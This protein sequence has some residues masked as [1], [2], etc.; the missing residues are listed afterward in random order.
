M[1]RRA[2]ATVPTARAGSTFVSK[3]GGLR[4]TTARA[5]QRGWT[6]RGGGRAASVKGWGIQAQSG[7]PSVTACYATGRLT[8][9]TPGSSARCLSVVSSNERRT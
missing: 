1:A 2:D 3:D 6:H 8:R 4:G 9:P 5:D 7:C